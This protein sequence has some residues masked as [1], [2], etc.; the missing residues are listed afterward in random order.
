MAKKKRRNY[1]K[2]FKEEYEARKATNRERFK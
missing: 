2:E 1:T